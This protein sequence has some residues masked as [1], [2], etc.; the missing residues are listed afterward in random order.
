M[1]NSVNSELTLV[2]IMLGEFPTNNF[3]L[4]PELKQNLADHKFIDHRDVQTL[5]PDWKILYGMTAVD[6]EYNDSS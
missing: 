3:H 2:V 4:F 1:N 5:V 6:R